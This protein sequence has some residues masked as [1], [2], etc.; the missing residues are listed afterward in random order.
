MRQTKLRLCVFMCVSALLI[1]SGAW[2]LQC[3]AQS[4]ERPGKPLIVFDHYHSLEEI[5]TYL[6]A[7]AAKYD[8]LATLVEVGRSRAHRTI[9]AIEITNSATG[10]AHEK[11]GFYLDGNI[12]GGEVLSGEGALYIIDLLLERYESDETIRSLVDT[13]VFYIVPIVNP[14][15]RE[16]SIA[17]PENHRWN[18]RPV[19]E[20]G[21][22]KFDEDPPEDLDND[23]RILQMIIEDSDGDW[24][25][26][27][28]DPRILA[29]RNKQDSG[30]IYY[31]R[32]SEGI[33]NDGDGHFNED[34]VGGVDVNRNFPS[35]WH[36][37]QYASGPYPLSEPESH[38]LAEY[39]TSRS[40]IAAIHTFHTS[41]GLILRFPTLADQNW[42]FP[43]TDLKDYD[44]IARRGKEITGYD[45]YTFSKKAIVDLMNPGHGVFNDWASNVFGVLAMTTEMWKHPFGRGLSLLEWNDRVLGG[46][47]FINWYPFEHPQ[48]GPV[49]LGGWDR[50]SLSNPPESMIA[51]ELRRNAQWV[52]SFAERLPRI[53]I[54]DVQA[55]PVT[56]QPG[57][58]EVNAHVANLGWMATS[59]EYAAKVLKITKPVTARVTLVNA[60]LVESADV[61]KLGVLPG[62]RENNQKEVFP[63]QWRVKIVNPNEPAFANITVTSAKAGVVR[64]R[65]DLFPR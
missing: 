64:H 30:G 5:T 29:R 40:N 55:K 51:E 54:T 47:G 62:R 18:I 65:I 39:I 45:N 37:G 57:F 50:W 24:E 14:D 15:G 25:K 26:S 38:A 31:R 16:I 46:K 22:G 58:F 20:D 4:D 7:V 60:E 1:N 42:D 48:L 8:N 21:D 32:L 52:L 44:V 11:P 10:P 34:R 2:S 61:I 13:S 27:E 33:D 6:K 3:E 12:H 17:T 9:Y 36:P 56:G 59:T 63:I 53:S 43:E 41:G 19:D 23:G 28:E 35:N 49:E